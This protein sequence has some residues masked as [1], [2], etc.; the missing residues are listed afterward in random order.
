MFG[1]VQVKCVLDGLVSSYWIDKESIRKNFLQVMRLS[2]DQDILEA[3]WSELRMTFESILMWLSIPR[4]HLIIEWIYSKEASLLHEHHHRIVHLAR[5][6]GPSILGQLA[7]KILLDC[8]LFPIDAMSQ[9]DDGEFVLSLTNLLS[10]L[11]TPQLTGTDIISLY[12]RI[13][14]A[15]TRLYL[16]PLTNEYDRLLA[17]LIRVRAAI[18]T[19][20]LPVYIASRDLL[21]KMETFLRSYLIGCKHH[22]GILKRAL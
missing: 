17:A 3:C 15:S 5:L 8:T 1:M 2:F 16:T 18:P 21:S 9:G 14:L 19:S 11:P 20:H 10:D 7:A 6:F 12:P 22:R 4:M 13:I